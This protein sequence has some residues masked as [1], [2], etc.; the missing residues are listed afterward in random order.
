MV[1]KTGKV[2]Q[3]GTQQRTDQHELFGRAVATVRS[4]RLGKI[5]KVTVQLPL[6]TGEGGPVHRARRARRIELGL[7]AGPGAGGDLLSR[8]MPLALPLVV[9]I[10]GRHYDRLGR[11]TWTS[12]LGAGRGQLRAALVDGSK[13]EMPKFPTASTRRSW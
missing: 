9:R 12:P 5:Q 2:M 3:V 4:G 13:T 10:L 1:K 6:S 11:H 8:A 7:L